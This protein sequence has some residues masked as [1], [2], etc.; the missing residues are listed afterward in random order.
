MC[1]GIIYHSRLT[2]VSLLF[3]L[4][5]GCAEEQSAEQRIGNA[6]AA[7]A[8]QDYA[9]ATI[10]L[11]NA[12]QQEA[13]NSR[14]R[15]LLGK[16]HLASADYP[17]AEKELRRAQELGASEGEVLPL[18]ARPLVL[19]GELEELSRLDAGQLHGSQHATVMAAR[20]L[21]ELAQGN[22]VEALR[23]V[24]LALELD[25][26]NFFAMETRARIH[27]ANSDYVLM[28][29]QLEALLA[30]DGGYAAAW[31]LLGDVDALNLLANALIG[32]GKSDE[33]ISTLNRVVALDPDSSAAQLRLGASLLVKGQS[34]AG[35]E[36]LEAAIELDPEFEQA[37]ILLVL[38]YVREG[39]FQKAIDAAQAYRSRNPTDVTPQNL[40]GR[41]Y[42][43]AGRDDD[44]MSAF[45][46]TLTL[47]M[48]NPGAH[49][50]L[51]EMAIERAEFGKARSHYEAILEHKP[52]HLATM[53]KLAEL[54]GIVGRP[55]SMLETLEQTVEL[56]PGSVRARVVLARA[57]LAMQRPEQVAVVF[58]DLDDAKKAVPAVLDAMARGELALCD[59][60]SA[61]Y[62]LERLEAA[63]S[64]LPELHYLKAM[65]AAGLKDTRGLRAELEKSVETR[66]DYFPA[67]LALARLH[68][69]NGE[70]A[71]AAE[72]A[73]VLAT[74][75][76]EFPDVLLLQSAL[77]QVEGDAYVSLDYSER[78][79]EVAPNT[80]P[81]GVWRASISS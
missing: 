7:I 18:L 5:L 29:Q 50:N 74:L 11:K 36:K 55:G 52:N 2:A 48:G 15:F 44:A 65:A 79:Y 10:E 34:R 49:L 12:L 67:R 46:S 23:Q 20:A 80:A 22:N 27:S 21:A 42:R 66:P 35:V 75:A 56:H 41:V 57:Y 72:Q 32:Q 17:A 54:E 68:L 60:A 4:V 33:A 9:A 59:Y 39:D 73:A 25:P 14:A 61:R 62:S 78:A 28:R 19:Q 64:D 3:L 26:E 63:D 47:H 58:S 31:L 43:S 69:K 38:N 81:Q 70:I 51:A 13:D 30:L 45:Q 1:K 8:R 53:L 24:N 40:L 71:L 6:T 77:A 37:E 16:V 76:P